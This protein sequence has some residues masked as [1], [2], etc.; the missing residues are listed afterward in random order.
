MCFFLIVI[1]NQFSYDVDNVV[2]FLED[3]PG[4]TQIGFIEHG[5][6]KFITDPLVVGC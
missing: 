2:H 3:R 6:A 1:S 5:D 4:Q